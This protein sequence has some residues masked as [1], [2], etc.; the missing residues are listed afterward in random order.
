MFAPW[1]FMIIL[2]ISLRIQKRKY[3]RYKFLNEEV[4]EW[5]PVADAK[6]RWT[7]MVILE[8]ISP[9]ADPSTPSVEFAAIREFSFRGVGMTRKEIYS[10]LL[11][12]KECFM[13]FLSLLKVV[14]AQRDYGFDNSQ[15]PDLQNNRSIEPFAWLRDV[16]SR[17][18]TL[19]N[20]SQSCCPH[21]GNQPTPESPR[22]YHH[23]LIFIRWG[24][25]DAYL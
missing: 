14:W 8:C 11:T 21:P 9:K 17:I 13:A 16:L 22:R 18:S 4:M 24:L 1:K 12:N 25:L 20:A 3:C 6:S 2:C 10:N 5:P 7:F 23:L 19:W 15:S